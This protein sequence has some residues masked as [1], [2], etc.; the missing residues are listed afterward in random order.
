MN[1]IHQAY[2]DFLTNRARQEGYKAFQDGYERRAPAH[3]NEY[4]GAWVEGWNQAAL[5]ALE[6]GNPIAMAA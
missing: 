1:S 5:D 4:A 3:V 2:V 6:A